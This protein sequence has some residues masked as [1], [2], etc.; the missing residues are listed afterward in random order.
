VVEYNNRIRGCIS[1]TAY[2]DSEI[3]DKSQV[4]NLFI[5]GFIQDLHAWKMLSIC[6]SDGLETSLTADLS[7]ETS[8]NRSCLSNDTQQPKNTRLEPVILKYCRTLS[9]MLR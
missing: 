8:H 1:F 4:S 6:C 2:L 9:W 3:A 7:R 5:V